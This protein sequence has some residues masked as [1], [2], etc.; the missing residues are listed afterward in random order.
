MKTI[1]LL[2]LFITICFFQAVNAQINL[3]PG[4]IITNENDTVYGEIDFRSGDR[5]AYHCSFKALN[6][7]KTVD[8]K[9][10]DIYGY[11]FTDDGKFYVSRTIS[12]DKKDHTLF[13]EYL[14]KGVIS[15][16]YYQ[17]KEKD[18]YFFFENEEGRL[19]E[20]EGREREIIDEDG[21]TSIHRSKKYMGVMK[22]LFQDSEKVLKKISKA[23]FTKSNLSKLVKDYHY[24][25][26]ETGEECI[27]FETKPDNRFVRFSYSVNAFAKIYQA[28]MGIKI[29][30]WE[31]GKMASFAPSLSLELGAYAPRVSNLFSLRANVGI[32][33]FVSDKEHFQSSFLYHTFSA[34]T[35]I[36]DAGL[37]LRFDLLPHK[38]SPFVEAGACY[39]RYLGVEATHYYETYG[40][41]DIKSK[42]I[43]YTDEII[44][45][46]VGFYVSLGVSIPSK[47]GTFTARIIGQ[48][49]FNKGRDIRSIG[50][51]I[52]Y[53]F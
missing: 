27:E 45:D 26:C 34:E 28:D 1:K 7:D 4:F 41:D 37:G 32:S 49:A 35:F 25:T 53:T 5:N 20:A 3:R 48:W 14:V 11:R 52:G 16:Y 36:L 2:F 50:A 9:P 15:L 46:Y 8:Y 51:G 43:D 31:V 39:T 10:G 30:M 29:N 18:S 17:D 19:V 47:A 6:T 22:Y 12:V 40:I 38:T 21:V 33:K 13:L 44:K 42:E 23:S 24:E